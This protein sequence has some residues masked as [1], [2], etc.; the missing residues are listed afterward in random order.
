MKPRQYF[1]V[2]VFLIF[3][4]L[5][6]FMSGVI[7]KY[8]FPHG[9]GRGR[10]QSFLGLSKNWWCDLHVVFVLVFFILL[11]IHVFKHKKY[12]VKYLSPPKHD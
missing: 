2:N 8:M 4:M 10:F 5:G 3:A 6:S 1:V 11:L 7:L 9:F 12:W